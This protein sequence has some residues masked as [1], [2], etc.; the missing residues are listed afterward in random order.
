MHPIQ[1]ILFIV[2]IVLMLTSGTIERRFRLG[3]SAQR[4]LAESVKALALVKLNI[5]WLDIIYAITMLVGILAKE[6]WDGVNET[7]V[8]NVKVPRLTAALIVSPIIYAA[9]YAK[10]IQGELS[11]LG[12]AVAFQNGFFWQA[13]FRSAQGNT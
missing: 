1:I 5:T 6:L 3:L 7:G 13:V 2:G 8:L 11:L 10:F 4:P 12:L 9:V